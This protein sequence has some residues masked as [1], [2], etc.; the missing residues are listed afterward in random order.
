MKILIT[1]GGC[2]VPID[3]VRFIG[4][5]S[6]GRYGAA[7]AYSFMDKLWKEKE[8]ENSSIIFFH[9]EG[10]ILPTMAS[11]RIGLESYRNYDEYLEVKTIIKEWQPDLI[12]SAAAISDYIVDKTP[13]KI[14]SDKDELV[15]TLKKGEKVISSFKELAPNAVVVGFKLLVDPTDEDRYNAV[16]K[17]FDNGADMVV[18][19]DLKKLREGNQSRLLLWKDGWENTTV[20]TECTHPSDLVEGIWKYVVHGHV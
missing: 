6:S 17:V 15:I 14:S 2:K 10:S 9:A 11:K 13:G 20:Y 3:D 1:S 19:N 7:L 12:I 5:F 8:M 4:N 18:Y 16:E